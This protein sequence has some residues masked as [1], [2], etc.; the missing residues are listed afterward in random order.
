MVE[1]NEDYWQISDFTRKIIEDM[2]VQ[3]PEADMSV[4][5]NTVDS[6]FK[7]LEKRGIHYVTRKA[8][9]KV[10]DSLDLELA[11]FTL[12]WRKNKN[13]NLET[14]F[15]MIQSKF[16]LRQLP[17]EEDISELP[18]SYQAIANAIYN[19][20]SK[21]IDHK[22]E[23]LV[24]QQLLEQSFDE[25]KEYIEQLKENDKKLLGESKEDDDLEK[26][27]Q[28]EREE[29]QKENALIMSTIKRNEVKQELEQEA[30][31]Q[32]SKLPENE[33]LNKVGWF[34][35]VEDLDKRMKFIN[36]YID[37]HIEKRM[38]AIEDTPGTSD[39]VHG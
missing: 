37:K 13:Y 38:S 5:F 35:W 17:V 14:I 27:I 24:K 6:W 20:L 36:D 4:H 2:S 39:K 10:Y 29:R 11:K 9:E 19:N 33:R 30:L 28:T 12:H 1:I 31:S 26:T 7:E 34:K 23:G 3:F 15:D 32:W 21:E 25:V 22:V 18:K 16:D 8:G